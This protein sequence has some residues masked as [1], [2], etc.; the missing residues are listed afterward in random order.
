MMTNSKRTFCYALKDD[1]MN[2]VCELDLYDCVEL[3]YDDT[4]AREETDIRVGKALFL[5]RQ[6]S[7]CLE[8]S[9]CPKSDSEISA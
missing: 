1:F 9:I 6:A 7:R 5:W 4:G 2:T 8:S 3:S